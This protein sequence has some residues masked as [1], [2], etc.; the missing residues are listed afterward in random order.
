MVYI[1][2]VEYI[3]YLVHMVLILETHTILSN[4]KINKG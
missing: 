2:T 3:D 4:F 1:S